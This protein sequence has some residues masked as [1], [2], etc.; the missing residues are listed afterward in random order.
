MAGGVLVGAAWLRRGG[1]GLDD[2]KTFLQCL[3]GP[4]ESPDIGCEG[5]DLD[6]DGDIDSADFAMF[7]LVFTEV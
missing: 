3:S 4:G 2:L 6:A 7:Q 5:G 1:A